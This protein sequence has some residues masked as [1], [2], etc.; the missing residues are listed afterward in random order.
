MKKCTFL[1]TNCCLYPPELLQHKP[2]TSWHHCIGLT[3]G[4]QE[5][6][7]GVGVMHPGVGGETLDRASFWVAERTLDNGDAVWMDHPAVPSQIYGTKQHGFILFMCS[8]RA[9]KTAAAFFFIFL[10]D[11]VSITCLSWRS[12]EP[13]SSTSCRFWCRPQSA[14]LPLGRKGMGRVQESGRRRSAGR[15][16]IGLNF[17]AL[18]TCSILDRV[19]HPAVDTPPLLPGCVDTGGVRLWLGLHV[20]RVQEGPLDGLHWPPVASAFQNTSVIQQGWRLLMH[21]C[22]NQQGKI[23][24]MP[25]SGC[26]PEIHGRLAQTDKSVAISDHIWLTWRGFGMQTNR[27]TLQYSI[28]YVFSEILSRQQMKTFSF[29]TDLW[30][31]TGEFSEDVGSSL[32]GCA[33]NANTTEEPTSI[34]MKT[35]VRDMAQKSGDWSRRFAD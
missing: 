15:G 4:W 24:Q 17:L 30:W 28:T 1:Y 16:Q 8:S 29:D 2:Q 31:R 9:V 7:L 6:Y 3:L 10:D 33:T 32:A 34:I 11:A 22:G 5:R 20:E 25:F 18:L 13:W 26:P 14:G 23:Q 21:H 27:V 35:S 19:S 12:G